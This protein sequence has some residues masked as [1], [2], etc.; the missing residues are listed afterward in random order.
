MTAPRRSADR[1]GQEAHILE[2]ILRRCKTVD[3]REEEIRAA[4][5]SVAREAAEIADNH[6]MECR[7]KDDRCLGCARDEE[8]RVIAAAI[9]ERFG[10][11]EK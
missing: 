7:T 6:D 5:E 4:L 9:R 3:Q 2:L 10:V 8:A 1:L 11:E